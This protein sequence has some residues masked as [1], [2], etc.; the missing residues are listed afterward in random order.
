MCLLPPREV[1]SNLPLVGCG[2]HNRDSL[3]QDGLWSLEVGMV[4]STQQIGIQGPYVYPCTTATCAWTRATGAARIALANPN[5]GPGT[6]VDA[7]W[8]TQITRIRSSGMLMLGYITSITSMGALKTEANVMAEIQR[9]LQL[10]THGSA[11]P[12]L[13]LESH[14][15]RSTGC[16]WCSATCPEVCLPCSTGVAELADA[17]KTSLMSLYQSTILGKRR[18]CAGILPSTPTSLVSSWILPVLLAPT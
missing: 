16:M 9:Y 13:T 14:V 11:K 3:P 10:C 1:A 17:P 4:Q 8:T 18:C 15:S 2:A 12:S 6:A 7:G 5:S